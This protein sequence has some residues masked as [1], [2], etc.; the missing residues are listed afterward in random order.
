MIYAAGTSNLNGGDSMC[1]WACV[2][3]YLCACGRKA[4]HSAYIADAVTT[5]SRADVVLLTLGDTHVG[6]L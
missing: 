6:E 1:N 5:A 2:A 4:N 3:P